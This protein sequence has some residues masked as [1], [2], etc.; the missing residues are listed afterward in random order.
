MSSSKVIADSQFQ[1]GIVG[2]FAEFS[3]VV[4][5]QDRALEPHLQVGNAGVEQLRGG[6]NLQPSFKAV[7]A[8]EAILANTTSLTT[9]FLDPVAVIAIVRNGCR[10]AM[11]TQT[12]F[13]AL[14]IGG[15]VVM[16]L[17]ARSY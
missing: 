7:N 2:F 1:A 11:T 13:F 6:K 15:I 17:H 16:A 10:I 4:A 8:A 3:E 14:G 12:V 9:F 5:E